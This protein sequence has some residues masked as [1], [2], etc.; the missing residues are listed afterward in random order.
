MAAQR[1]Y[2]TSKRTSPATTTTVTQGRKYINTAA[3]SQSG[4]QNQYFNQ[5]KYSMPKRNII[6][7]EESAK[8]QIPDIKKRYGED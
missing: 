8:N 6:I 5:R 3:A 1:V 2:N 7:E 4:G